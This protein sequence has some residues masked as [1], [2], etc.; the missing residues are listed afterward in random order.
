MKR[1]Y[2]VW[3]LVLIFIILAFGCV[4][5][6]EQ[7]SCAC[8][9]ATD[10]AQG[11]DCDDCQCVE[12]E[13]GDGDGG[14]PVDG[15]DPIDG[16]DPVDGDDPIDGDDPAD[17]DDP[18][19]GDDPNDDPLNVN[20]NYGNGEA[21]KNI[22]SDVEYIIVTNEEM[23]PAFEIL[24][25][26]KNTKGIPTIIAITEEIVDDHEGV[27]DAEKLRNYLIEMYGE[28]PLKWVLLGGDTPMVPHREF[29]CSAD[30]FG[31]YYT[32][33][34]VA[35]DLYF[36]DLDGTWDDNHNGT[37]GE[38]EDDLDMYPELHVTRAPVDNAA[39]AAGFVAKV[40]DYEQDPPDNFI[41]RAVFI[42]E[43]TGFFGI[44]ASLGLD[45]LDKETF[46]ERFEIRKLYGDP[47]IHEGAEPN[48][49]QNQI[50]VFD[51]SPNLFAHFGHGGGADVSYL[52]RSDLEA[53]TNSPKNGIYVS[54]A[55]YSGAFHDTKNPGGDLFVTNPNGGGVAY[56]GN[57][58]IGLGF[59]SGMNFIY[60][61]YESLFNPGNPTV[62][63]G[64]LFS[65]AR[66]NFT[67]DEDMHA[68]EHQDRYT[69][70]VMVVFGEPEMPIWIDEPTIMDVSMPKGL[71]FG[72]NR[73]R[74]KVEAEGRPLAGARLTIFR[75]GEF[76]YRGKTNSQGVAEICLSTDTAGNVDIGITAFQ[77]LPVHEILSV[78]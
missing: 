20:H 33:G 56:L 64:N 8:S 41:N 51:N 78:E 72:K 45:P 75:S 44:D 25:E 76:L 15:D 32:D 57:T 5:G 69:A 58:E 27:D 21:S 50:D 24:A 11:Y 36:A 38:V 46:P 48:T 1:C 10:C 9:S 53:L 61:F 55:C 49:W 31:E 13:A 2:P 16:D 18:I 29:W 66:V 70:L 35:A 59:P 34:L 22:L 71:R 3:N 14:D 26:W 6:E 43:A 42:S 7:S 23:A 68:F 52:G 60:A 67:N 73:F 47:T 28:H 12:M 40:L 17:G 74:V 62:R 77:A 65:K 19:D 37:W 30:V 63:L 4:E 54:T 39:E